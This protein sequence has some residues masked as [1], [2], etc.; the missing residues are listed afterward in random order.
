MHPKNPLFQKCLAYLESLP[1]IEA[2]IRVEPYS[3]SEV[4]ADGE[5]I[6]NTSNKSVNYVCE[7]KTGLTNDVIEQVTEYSS[8]LGK[9]LKHNERPL[10]VTR[11]L[12]NLVIEQLL[13]ENV[14]FIDVDG[15][16]YL[17]SPGIYVLVRNQVSKESAS[18]SLEITASALQVIYALLSQPKLFAR[19]YDLLDKEIAYISGVTPKIVKSTLK[20]LQDLDYIT[21]RHGRYKIVDYVRL[22][23]RWELGYSEKLRA[24]LLLGAFTPI[25]KDDFSEVRD[26]IKEGAE[27]YDYLIGGELAAS[28]MIEYLRPISATLHLS[29]NSDSRQIAVK[30]RLKPDPEGNITFL[31]TFGHTEHQRI[32]LRELQ[33]SLADPL[34]VHAELVQT[35]NSRLKETAQLIYDRY[36]EELAQKH[37][38]L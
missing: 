28:V 38:W 25:G 30:L 31:Q 24:K 14:E 19:G 11:G 15:N 7:I 17:N 4:L 12:S 35:G 36:I 8:N 34:L 32:E 18:K 20:K 27:K 2:T 6:I 10:L 16:I 13:K 1:S 29:N 22:L 23:E 3:S 26:K 5:L 21:Y 33:K 9:R 37:D